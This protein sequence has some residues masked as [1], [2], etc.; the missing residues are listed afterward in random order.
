MEP[1][2]DRNHQWHMHEL[3]TAQITAGPQDMQVRNNAEPGRLYTDQA[4]EGYRR[5]EGALPELCGEHGQADEIAS[6]GFSPWII[7]SWSAAGCL[8]RLPVL[9]CPGVSCLPG[10]R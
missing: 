1:G 10:M 5:T 9:Q 3:G 8:W 4:A 7:I 2:D 6:I